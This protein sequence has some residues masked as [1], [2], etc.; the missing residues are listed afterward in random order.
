MLFIFN[1][2]TAEYHNITYISKKSMKL[3][4]TAEQRYMNEI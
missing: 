1:L 3:Y 2:R 4:N